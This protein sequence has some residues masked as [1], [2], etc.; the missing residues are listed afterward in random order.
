MR[1]AVNAESAVQDAHAKCLSEVVATMK[2]SQVMEMV[3]APLSPSQKDVK[4]FFSVPFAVNYTGKSYLGVPYT[5]ADGPAL[6]VT[7]CHYPVTV[8]Y[9]ALGPGSSDDKSL[10]AS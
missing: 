10:F 3:N 5:H 6:Q 7:V 2:A 1:I 4:T 8:I 9:K